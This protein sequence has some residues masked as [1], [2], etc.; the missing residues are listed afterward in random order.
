MPG[1]AEGTLAE[2]I[3]ELKPGLPIVRMSGHTPA[4]LSAQLIRGNQLAFLQKPF[5]AQTLLEKVRATL[6]TPPT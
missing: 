5:T 3:A 4:A 1:T 6:D 2:H